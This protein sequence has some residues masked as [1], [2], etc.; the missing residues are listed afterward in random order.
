M[1]PH[2]QEFWIVFEIMAAMFMPHF[3]ESIKK[4]TPLYFR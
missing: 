1:S 4:D 3:E 2:S